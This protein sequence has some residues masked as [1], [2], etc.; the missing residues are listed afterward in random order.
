[1]QSGKKE[2]IMNIQLGKEEIRLSLFAD[3]MIVYLEDL[4]ISAQNLLK[5]IS[6]FSTVSGYKINVQKLQAFLYTSNRQIAKS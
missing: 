5:M 3:H 4:F 1:M 6:D 2:K